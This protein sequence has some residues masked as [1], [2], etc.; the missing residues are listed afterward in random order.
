[1]NTIKYKDLNLQEGETL[2]DMGCGE[3]RHSIGGLIE[4]SANIIGLDLCL[5]DVQTAKERLNDF[6][7]AGLTTVCNFGVANIV[8][9]PFQESSLDAVICSEV[10]EHVDSPNKSV[11][12]LIRVCLLY[13]SDAA[14]DP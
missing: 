5:K 11:Q 6:D 9:I 3:G 8:N 2:L 13:T 12:E 14:D 1:M 10:L 4:T 7:I